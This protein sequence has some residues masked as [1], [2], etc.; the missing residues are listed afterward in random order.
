VEY[1]PNVILRTGFTF[2]YKRLSLTGQYAYT[3]KQFSDADNSISTTSAIYGIIPAYAVMD[4]SGT[5][6][7]RLL[8]ISAGINNVANAV[9]FTRRAEGYPGPGIIPGDPINMY[10]TLQLKL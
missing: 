4:V 6:S 2:A 10:L 9:Y 8:A 3:S 5:Y 7:W 1:V